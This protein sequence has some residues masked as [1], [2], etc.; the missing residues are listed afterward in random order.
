MKLEYPKEWFERSAEIEGNAEV[1]A[2][3]PPTYSTTEPYTND[4]ITALD[5]RIAFGQF[6]ALWRRNNGWNAERLAAEAGI[7]TEE[8]LEIEHDPHCEPEAN[9]VYKLA[10]VFKVPS[11]NLLELAGLVENRSPHLREEAI[12]FAA[13]SESLAALSELERQAFEAFVGALTCETNA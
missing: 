13:R 8:V 9:A 2:G 10:G 3:V 12:R 11:R 5:T 7:D 1:G 6:V 4:K